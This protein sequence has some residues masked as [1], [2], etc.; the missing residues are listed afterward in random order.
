MFAPYRSHA[1][2][3]RRLDVETSVDSANPHKLIAMLLD[4]AIASINRAKGA[5]A[6]GDIA[7]RG[8]AIS[9]AIRIVDEGLKAA[10]DDRG[11]EIAQHLRDLYDYVCRRLLSV[12]VS[13]DT[14]PL[15]EAASLL[16]EVQAGWAQIA[17]T[18]PRA[19]VAGAAR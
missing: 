8:E 5:I 15:D 16:G 19:V 3:Y 13:N 1:S 18:G 10:L 4:G 12:S 2:T 7:G 9:R 11:G 14:A 17:P 6:N